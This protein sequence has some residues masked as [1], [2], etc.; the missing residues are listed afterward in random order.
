MAQK[1][2]VTPNNDLAVSPLCSVAQVS[3]TVSGPVSWQGALTMENLG[4]HDVTE[5]AQDAWAGTGFACPLPGA[6][7]GG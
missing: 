6:R 2:G 5:G 3:L 4:R 7:D 1:S